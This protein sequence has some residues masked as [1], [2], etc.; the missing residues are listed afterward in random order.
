M[1]DNTRVKLRGSIEQCLSGDHY[2][3]LDASSTVKVE[4]DRK[5][6]NGVMLSP[7]DNCEFQGK[8]DIERSK[9]CVNVKQIS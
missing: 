7:E 2:L 9:I 3:F 6:W 1:N 8:V 4:I 5:Y